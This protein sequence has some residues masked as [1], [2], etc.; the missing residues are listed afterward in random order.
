MAWRLGFDIGSTFTDFVLQASHTGAVV[1]G[2]ELTTS[3]DPAVGVFRRL[4]E[5]LRVA[6]ADLGTV[7]QAVH[8]T[9]LG[10]NVVIERKRARPFLPT[11]RG[12]RDMLEIQRQVR[13]NINDLFVDKH[14][15]GD[16]AEPDR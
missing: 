4:V 14:P 8:G 15:P 5:V 1:V 7:D 2:K 13:Y 9:T 16:P 6:G 12:G 11:T 3:N 10:A